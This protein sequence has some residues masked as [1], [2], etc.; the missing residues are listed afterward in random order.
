MQGD[1]L[2]STQNVAEQRICNIQPLQKLSDGSFL[3]AMV[4]EGQPAQA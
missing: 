3:T 4:V 2:L 1:G